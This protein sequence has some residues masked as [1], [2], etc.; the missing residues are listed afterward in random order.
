MSKKDFDYKPN[1]KLVDGIGQF[2]KWYKEFC[3][4]NKEE[5]KC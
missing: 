1:T 5:N 2:V 4:I 3:K